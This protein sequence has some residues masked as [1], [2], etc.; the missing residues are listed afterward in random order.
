MAAFVAPLRFRKK[1]SLASFAVPPLTWTVTVLQAEATDIS[2]HR[3]LALIWDYRGE[4]HLEWA[5]AAAGE[6]RR[7]PEEAAR[8]S[9]ARALVILEQIEAQKMLIETDREWLE[10]LRA[11][12][13]KNKR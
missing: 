1:V 8:A 13:P 7:R 4:V 11:D 5:K 10:K 3:N 9:Y 12:L 6:E 2:W